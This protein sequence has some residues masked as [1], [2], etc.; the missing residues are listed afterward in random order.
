MGGLK[1]VVL[2]NGVGWSGLYENIDSSGLG[3]AE[4]DLYA[5]QY[6]YI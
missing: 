4:M 6:D 3:W 5:K 1:W 2:D